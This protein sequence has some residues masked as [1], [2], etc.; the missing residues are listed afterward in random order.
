MV[1]LG[2]CC[3]DHSTIEGSGVADGGR[4]GASGCTNVCKA[5]NTCATCGT[6]GAGGRAGPSPDR[7]SPAE[8]CEGECGTLPSRERCNCSSEGFSLR[9]RTV[10]GWMRATSFI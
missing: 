8:E 2:V 3:A 10:S 4:G 6:G 7:V 1:G 5:E 9:N